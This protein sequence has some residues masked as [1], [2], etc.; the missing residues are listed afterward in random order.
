MRIGNKF[1]D[2]AVD[3][4]EE[5]FD[6]RVTV[7]T[8]CDNETGYY[9]FCMMNGKESSNL[10]IIYSPLHHSHC[11]ILHSQTNVPL[12]PHIQHFVLTEGVSLWK[13][14]NTQK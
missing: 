7:V 12:T 5:V 10:F 9:A 6:V 11:L 3:E 13:Q 1:G 8:I 4:S 2:V 14:K